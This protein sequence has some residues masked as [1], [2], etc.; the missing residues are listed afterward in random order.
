MNLV[1]NLM[2]Q[3]D[4]ETSTDIG[5]DTK[6][7]SASMKVIAVLTMWFSYPRRRYPGSLVWRS[8]I[9]LTTESF[10]PRRWRG[11]LSPQLY[12]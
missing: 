4:S 3:Q 10:C 1:L 6:D 5:R 2:T 7:D 9:S 11:C 12:L 8:S